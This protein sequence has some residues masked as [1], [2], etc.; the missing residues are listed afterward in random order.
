MPTSW[1]RLSLL[2]SVNSAASWWHGTHQDA[3][4]LTMLIFPFK[5]AGSSPGTC[6]PSVT[7]PCNDG[8]AVCGAGRPIKAEGIREGSPSPRPIQKIAATA[9]NVSAGSASSQGEPRDGASVVVGSLI[10]SPTRYA[11]REDNPTN[12]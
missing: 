5:T 6:A 7:R 12:H 8:N 3:Q 4:T 1:S 11:E 2:N 10:G 9:R